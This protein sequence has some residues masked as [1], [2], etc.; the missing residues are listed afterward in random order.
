MSNLDPKYRETAQ[1]WGYYVRRIQAGQPAAFTRLYEESLPYA[2]YTV[3]RYLDN[4]EDSKDIVQEGYIKILQHIHGLREPEKYMGWMKRILINLS[5]NFLKSGQPNVFVGLE[6]EEEINGQALEIQTE[7]TGPERS[8]INQE[9]G[10]SVF[11]LLRQLPPKQAIVLELF[12]MDELSIQEIAQALNLPEGTVKSRLYTGRKKLEASI[13][14]Y[15]EESGVKLYA[16]AFLPAVLRGLDAANI[17]RTV[18]FDL[19]KAVGEGLQRA[20]NWPVFTAPPAP[21]PPVAP[22]PPTAPVGQGYWPNGYSLPG[23]P[24]TGAAAGTGLSAGAKVGIAVVTA[25]AVGLGVFLS[26][27]QLEKSRYGKNASPVTSAVQTTITDDTKVDRHI[28]TSTENHEKKS[29]WSPYYELFEAKI[30]E[31]EENKKA[32]VERFAAENGVNS[33]YGGWSGGSE[34]EWAV[35]NLGETPGG[36]PELYIRMPFQ[37]TGHDFTLPEGIIQSYVLEGGQL[38]KKAEFWSGGKGTLLTNGT[39]LLT[40]KNTEINGSWVDSNFLSYRKQPLI[41]FLNTV[42]NQG[43]E[44]EVTLSGQAVF[45]SFYKPEHNLDTYLSMDGN[46]KAAYERGD[47]LT[48]SRMTDGQEETVILMKSNAAYFSEAYAEVTGGHYKVLDFMP[49][50]ARSEELEEILQDETS[51]LLDPADSP[52]LTNFLRAGQLAFVTEQ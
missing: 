26:Y 15:E 21:T 48:F 40:L 17:S 52:D 14:H 23:Q 10:Q 49:A 32:L 34:V 11:Y 33:G 13:S 31:V 42:E 41:D 12:Y 39:D 8:Y 45:T 5:L 16:T 29:T 46:A 38:V 47:Y 7:Q 35:A 43:G 4:P 24:G 6:P 18:S 50:S 1:R 28:A 37:W 30:G 3:K 9:T 25:T 22:T 2:F 36:L 51:M 44:S 27:K 19:Y 20:L